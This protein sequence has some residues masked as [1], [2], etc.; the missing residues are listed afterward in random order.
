MKIGERKWLPWGRR[1][2]VVVVGARKGGAINFKEPLKNLVS[3]AKSFPELHLSNCGNIPEEPELTAWSPL[4]NSS[5][6]G[7]EPLR[8]LPACPLPVECDRGQLCDT[9]RTPSPC[10]LLNPAELILPVST[11]E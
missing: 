5:D 2:V 6:P 1:S 10:P 8:A 3:K 9:W 7:A 4:M 11:P